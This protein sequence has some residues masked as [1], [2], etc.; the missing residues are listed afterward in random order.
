MDTDEPYAGTNT[1]AQKPGHAPFVYLE[2]FE[3]GYQ[4]G[5]K[6]GFEGGYREG[7]EDGFDA[8]SKGE[9]RTAYMAAIAD[10]IHYLEGRT[11]S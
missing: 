3:E 7:H 5:Y 10:M 2:G 4:E 9:Y 11:K 6:D 1:V 8:G